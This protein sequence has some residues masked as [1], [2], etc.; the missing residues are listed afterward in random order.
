MHSTSTKSSDFG[1]VH[2][3]PLEPSCSHR[4]NVIVWTT[5]RG[6]TLAGSSGYGFSCDNADLLIDAAGVAIRDV[7]ESENCLSGELSLVNKLKQFV[8]PAPKALRIEWSDYSVPRLRASFWSAL[9]QEFTDGQRVVCAC[10][11]GHG[12]T[13]TALACLIVADIVERGE[14][15][16]AAAV[17]KTVRRA[18]CERAVESRAQ[19]RYVAAV[20]AWLYQGHNGEEAYRAEIDRQYAL[21]DSIQEA[22]KP[23]ATLFDSL[24]KNVIEADKKDDTEETIKA[25]KLFFKR[26]DDVRG[27]VDEDGDEDEDEY[28]DDDIEHRD[29]DFLSD[30]GNIVDGDGDI[31]YSREEI[32]RSDALKRYANSLPTFNEYIAWRDELA[33]EKEGGSQ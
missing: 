21:I 15:P 29:T 30:L 26:D 20:A 27:F 22:K 12:R 18:H 4:G 1:V 31:M 19:M 10:H 5:L 17:I 3:R 24:R 33:R 11:A 25:A 9:V 13:G 32:E 2:G 7:T 14:R 6:A 23:Q 8:L 16:D 28:S